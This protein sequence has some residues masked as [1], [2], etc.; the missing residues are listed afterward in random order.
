MSH[1]PACRSFSTYISVPM[2]HF[3]CSGME[4]ALVPRPEYGLTGGKKDKPWATGAGESR[5]ING[6]E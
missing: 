1:I 3:M 6:D 2:S 4:N 5:G